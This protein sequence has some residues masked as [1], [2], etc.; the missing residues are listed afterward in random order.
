M[1]TDE[2]GGDGKPLEDR[3][4]APF[5]EGAGGYGLFAFG[6][7]EDRAEGDWENGDV[8]EAGLSNEAL[9]EAVLFLET[10]PVNEKQIARIASI[11]EGDVE[12]ALETLKERYGR[13]SSGLE[14]V[15]IGGGVTVAPK[16]C[17]WDVLK[18]RYGRKNTAKLSRAAMETLAIIA[19]SQPITRSEIEA[20]RGVQA[21]GMIRLLLERGLIRETGKKDIAGRPVQF[22]TTKEFLSLFRLESIA[23]LPRLDETDAERFGL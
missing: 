9:V 11:A 13:P 19:Y 8:E 16:R 10:E 15:R 5:G 7:G 18:E 23:D 3:E 2:E 22:G 4:A 20:I 17:Y 14:L 6:P 21:D 12:A 1:G